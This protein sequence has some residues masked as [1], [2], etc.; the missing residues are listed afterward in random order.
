[1]PPVRVD[2]QGVSRE[3]RNQGRVH[4]DI[5]DVRVVAEFIRVVHI[6]KLEHRLGDP[7][8]Q[9]SRGVAEGLEV[10]DVVAM[11]Q[12]DRL[13]G[14]VRFRFPGRDQK[15]LLQDAKRSKAQ[16]FGPGRSD[17][18]RRHLFLVEKL[19]RVRV[20]GSPRIPHGDGD[21]P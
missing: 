17:V 16:G 12:H 5:E 21:M 13:E 2:N 11:R 14:S 15:P 6:A 9:G 4:R 3:R 7:V 8:T 19:D 20:V 18:H 10:V 1:M